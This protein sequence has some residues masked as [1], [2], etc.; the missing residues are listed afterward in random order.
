MRPQEQEQEKLGI[1]ANCE[2]NRNIRGNLHSLSVYCTAHGG[3]STPP[4]KCKWKSAKEKPQ[5]DNEFYL[6]AVALYM[7]SGRPEYANQGFAQG[8]EADEKGD[9]SFD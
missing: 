2:C 7:R 6:G 5:V 4:N 1:C 8:S 9:E 3:W